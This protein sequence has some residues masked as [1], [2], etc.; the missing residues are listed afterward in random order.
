MMPTTMISNGQVR[1]KLRTPA[2]WTANKIP[3]VTSNTGPRMACM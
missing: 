1:L 2:W 3:I